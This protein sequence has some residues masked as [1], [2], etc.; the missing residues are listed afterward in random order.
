M[1]SFFYQCLES[2]T[3]HRDTEIVTLFQ[4]NEAGFLLSRQQARGLNARREDIAQQRIYKM[5]RP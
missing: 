3:L 1:P 5:N 4:I 2:C